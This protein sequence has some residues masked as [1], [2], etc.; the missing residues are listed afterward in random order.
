M[1]KLIDWFSKPTTQT[2]ERVSWWVVAIIYVFIFWVLL[3][4]QGCASFEKVTGYK[5]NTYWHNEK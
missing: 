2:F 4:I 5:Q 3:S 1:K